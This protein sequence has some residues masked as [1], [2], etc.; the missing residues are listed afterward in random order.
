VSATEVNVGSPDTGRPVSE[1]TTVSAENVR[2]AADAR[3]RLGG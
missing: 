1:V 2:I 3:N